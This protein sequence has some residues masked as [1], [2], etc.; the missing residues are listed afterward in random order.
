MAIDAATAAILADFPQSALIERNATIRGINNSYRYDLTRIWDRSLS[1]CVFCMLNPSTADGKTDDATINK[2]MRFAFLWGF[3]GIVVV[4]LFAY[5]ATNPKE[6]RPLPLQVA[7]GDL[8][9][10]FIEV[11]AGD[12][13]DV[14]C[15][16][17]TNGG[18]ARTL[19]R[20]AAV[21]EMLH[22]VN[23]FK[24]KCLRLT[25]DGHPW[26]PLYVPYS[27]QRVPFGV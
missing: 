2:C 3:G 27:A 17:G 12:H 26:H 22:R 9:D 8:N 7:I 5:R 16:W 1:L 10:D 20:A 6:L 18:D 14:I 24:P 21:S 13:G 15:A 11:A 19:T 4:N 23:F 25:K